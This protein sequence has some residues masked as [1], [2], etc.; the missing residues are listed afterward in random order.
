[1]ENTDKNSEVNLETFK[2]LDSADQ[3]YEHPF[4][5][6]SGLGLNLK[7]DG[8]LLSTLG[9]FVVKIGITALSGNFNFST[10]IP[11]SSTM[12]PQP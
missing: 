9:K 8:G 3:Y 2:G 7:T 5:A 11:P 1:M 4:S 10:I 12:H 6:D